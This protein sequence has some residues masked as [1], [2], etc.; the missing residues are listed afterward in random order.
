MSDVKIVQDQ[1]TAEKCFSVETMP[2]YILLEPTWPYFHYNWARKVTARIAVS[3]N[4]PPGVYGMQLVPGDPIGSISDDL[5]YEVGLTRLSS[6]R[7]GGAWQIVVNV[8]E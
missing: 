3:Q 5:E 4:C 8:A 6:M 7:V 1:A 2:E